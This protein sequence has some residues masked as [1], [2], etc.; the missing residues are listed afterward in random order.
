MSTM[1]IGKHHFRRNVEQGLYPVFSLELKRRVKNKE[2]TNIAVVGEAGSG[3]SYMGMQI[4]LTLDKNFCKKNRNPDDPDDQADQIVFTYKTY[5]EEIQNGKM[6]TPIEFDEPSYAMGKREW[7]KQLNQALV[8][9]LESQRFL[10]RPLIIPIININLLDKTVRNYL[11]QFQVHVLGRGKARVYRMRPSQATDKVYRYLFCTLEY[12]I[13]NPECPKDTCLGCRD[14]PTCNK[15]RARYERKKAATQ[16]GRYDEGLE[17]ANRLETRQTSLDEI[18]KRILGFK[19]RFYIDN[20]IDNTRLKVSI[21]R[22]LGMKLSL[23]KV[24]EVKVFLMTLFPDD[25]TMEKPV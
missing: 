23:G 17:L 24:R 16:L 8:K 12:P 10:V 19:D 18:A 5:I 6:G 11:I 20:R 7:Y 14:R 22:D 13:I 25:F 4:A 2:A 15:L 9:T 3:K 1:K 21:Q